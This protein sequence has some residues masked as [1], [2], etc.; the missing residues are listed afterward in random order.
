MN[1]IVI[2]YENVQPKTLTHLS[3][4]GYFIVLCVG[5][6]QK[7]LPVVLIKSLI[8][9]GKNCRIIE[10]PKAGKNA[11]DFIIVDEMARITTEYQFNA[12]YIIS[13]DKG[14]GSIIHY[15]LTKGRIQQAKRLDSIDDILPDSQNDNVQA[16]TM[17]IL[18][19]KVQNQI[20]KVNQ[21][22]PRSLPNKSQSQFNWVNSL[23]K[24]ENLTE[25]DINALIK[26]V[27]FS[28]AQSIPLKTYIDKAKAKL[29]SLEKRHHPNKLETQ[30]N[31]LKSFFIN[32][33][34]TRSQISEIQQAIFSK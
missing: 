25:K 23:L 33:G 15:Y 11:L 8:M 29:N 19:S 30:I 14:F 24:A 16:V 28:P 13:K 27:D 7:L 3:P 32:N 4:N 2:D 1:L 34:L 12:L 26:M 18:A 21:I 10:C 6:N 5:E 31:W 20:D 9:F 17:S 22:S